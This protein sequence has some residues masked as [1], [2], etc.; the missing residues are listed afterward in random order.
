[1]KC[2]ICQL[3]DPDRSHFW[4]K[5][6]IRESLY[7]ATYFPRFD[8]LTNEKI[9]FK[10]VDTYLFSDFINKRNLKEW[11]KRQSKENQQ[12]Y[13]KNLLIKRKEQKNLIYCPA[14]VELT[15]TSS[16]PGIITYNNI[17]GNYYGLCKEIGFI[18]RGFNNIDKLV[19]IRDLGTIICDSREQKPLRW[20]NYE[21]G[22]LP[23][24][25]YTLKDDNFNIFIERKSI[26][27][28]F[29]TFGPKNFERFRNEI[30]K[31]KENNAYLILLVEN[32][33]NHILALD[34]SN[35]KH[36]KMTSA[37]LFHQIR[38]LLQTF[39]CWQ[40]A[41]CENRT[42]MQNLIGKIFRLGDL[43]KSFDIQLARDRKI[44]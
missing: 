23:Y 26:N 6:R 29:G 38:E 19:E 33:I 3:E 40:I 17:F 5:H 12:I 31:V 43:S 2:K 15:T 8:K 25:D 39:D 11:L 37:Y 14:Q 32:D 27:D 24:G 41:F 4:K 36:T 20:T 7:Y 35:Y 44:I 42:D 22:T 28:V 21:V 10:D 9:K 13:L 18:S 16:I 1:M 34:N 30:I